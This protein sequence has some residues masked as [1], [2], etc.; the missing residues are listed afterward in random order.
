MLQIVALQYSYQICW[1]V[2][3]RLA[4]KEGGYLCLIFF[5]IFYGRGLGPWGPGMVRKYTSARFVTYTTGEMLAESESSLLTGM[6][7]LIT[8]N[9]WFSCKTTFLIWST[10]NSIFPCLG[11]FAVTDYVYHTLAAKASGELCLKYIFSFGALPRSPL[12]HRFGD[13]LPAMLIIEL[14]LHFCTSTS[15][16]NMSFNWMV[17]ISKSMLFRKHLWVDSIWNSCKKL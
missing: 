4:V 12:L 14:T 9:T 17:V 7:S 1:V 10:H 6:V 13:H 16:Y 3:C 5:L 11:F 2:G 15:K 8:I